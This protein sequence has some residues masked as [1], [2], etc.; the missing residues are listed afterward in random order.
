MKLLRLLPVLTIAVHLLLPLFSLVAANSADTRTAGESLAVSY[1]LVTVN[2]P[3]CEP[4]LADDYPVLVQH[5]RVS[6]GKGDSAATG[7]ASEWV[8]PEESV[9]SEL[10]PGRQ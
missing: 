1:T 6:P 9:T 2:S 3:D 10:S 8:Y 4:S 7:V 5:R